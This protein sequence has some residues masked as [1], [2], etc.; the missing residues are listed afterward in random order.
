MFPDFF[1]AQIQLI[2]ARNT[3]LK[4]VNEIEIKNYIG[5]HVYGTYYTDV[6][7]DF[8]IDGTCIYY[9]YDHTT[10]ITVRIEKN[11]VGDWTISEDPDLGDAV[12]LF[13]C[14]G[15]R[16]ATLPPKTGWERIDVEANSNLP[17]INYYHMSTTGRREI[18]I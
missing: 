14:K 7:E 5:G 8:G 18:D 12:Q 15:S 3:A 9:K 4:L 6:D 11:E 13:I 16:C 2:A 10:R 1:V 17:I